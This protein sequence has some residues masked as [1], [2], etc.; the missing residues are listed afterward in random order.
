MQRSS[1]RQRS[2]FSGDAL[3]PHPVRQWK[4]TPTTRSSAGFFFDPRPN[5][6]SDNVSCFLCGTSLSHWD[7]DDDPSREHALNA[8]SCPYVL[9]FLT[10]Q[11]QLKKTY[12]PNDDVLCAARLATFVNWPLETTISTCSAQNVT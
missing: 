2:F 3:W 9:L 6:G 12:A 10:R 11:T 1:E 5:P 8:P 4:P 7:P